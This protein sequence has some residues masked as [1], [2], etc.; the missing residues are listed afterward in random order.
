MLQEGNTAI[1]SSCMAAINGTPASNAVSVILEH[2]DI[3]ANVRNQVCM[4]QYQANRVR[5]AGVGVIGP[6]LVLSGYRTHG[7]ISG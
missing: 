7:M 2:K 1:M 3:D 4:G 5:R 6:C